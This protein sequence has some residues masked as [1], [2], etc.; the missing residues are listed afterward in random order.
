MRLFLEH[1]AELLVFAAD[2]RL[3]CPLSGHRRHRCGRRAAAGNPNAWPAASPLSAH[4]THRTSSFIRRTR[5]LVASVRSAQR[6]KQR[7]RRGPRSVTASG[8]GSSIG[9][10]ESDAKPVNRAPVAE[11][12]RFA[13][14]QEL[15]GPFPRRAFPA[16]PPLNKAGLAGRACS[17]QKDFVSHQKRTS[18]T[19]LH[20]VEPHLWSNRF[21]IVGADCVRLDG[22]FRLRRTPRLLR[23]PLK[24]RFSSQMRRPRPRSPTSAIRRLAALNGSRRTPAPGRFWPLAH[25]RQAWNWRRHVAV[26]THPGAWG[27]ILRK[28][29][30]DAPGRAAGRTQE[31]ERQKTQQYVIHVCSC[32][33]LPENKA[34]CP[35]VPRRPHRPLG[36]PPGLRPGAGYF[37][38]GGKESS[39]RLTTRPRPAARFASPACSLPVPT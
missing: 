6:V 29:P 30:R 20:Q 12:S 25:G 39:P 18:A 23:W 5:R 1:F 33:R 34:A 15:A 2:V 4:K 11:R 13:G 3:A 10:Q 24:V 38:R 9:F 21:L 14:P 19:S 32:A 16:G 26:R 37:L 27:P 17:W 7:A 35:I 8:V 31:A 36:P 28:P 22:R